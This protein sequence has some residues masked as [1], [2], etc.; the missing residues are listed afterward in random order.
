M[1]ASNTKIIFYSL[2][3][4]F[5]FQCKSDASDQL[6]LSDNQVAWRVDNVPFFAKKVQSSWIKEDG[7]NR[8]YLSGSMGSEG[9][10]LTLNTS[11]DGLIGKYPLKE[12]VSILY[13]EKRGDA[14]AVFQSNGCKVIKGFIEITDVDTKMKTISGRF[15]ADLCGVKKFILYGNTKIQGGQFKGVKYYET[16]K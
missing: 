9:V 7:N 12:N 6:I 3:A 4:V 13:N 2:L 14:L 10:L 1:P 5:L 8:I 16:T 11:N 15:E